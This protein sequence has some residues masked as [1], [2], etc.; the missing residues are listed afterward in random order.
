MMDE[1]AAQFIWQVSSEE[2]EYFEALD[3]LESDRKQRS[4]KIEREDD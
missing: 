4:N 2:Q 1:D 3:E